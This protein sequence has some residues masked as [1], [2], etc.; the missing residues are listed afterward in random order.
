MKTPCV[1]PTSLLTFPEF[2]EI[3]FEAVAGLS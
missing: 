3:L 1:P 2:L